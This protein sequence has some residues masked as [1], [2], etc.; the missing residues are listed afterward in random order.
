MNALPIT[1]AFTASVALLCSGC[2]LSDFLAPKSA[3]KS[4]AATVKKVKTTAYTHAE[5]S[6]RAWGRSNAIGGRLQHGKV[7]SASADWSRYPVGTRFKIQQ[8]G[9]EYVIDDYGSA[10]VGTNTIDLYTASMGEMRRW[11]VRQVDIEILEWGSFE[12]SLDI[13]EDR[14]R[15]RHVRTMVASLRQKQSALASGGKT[16]GARNSNIQL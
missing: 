11:G 15:N 3:G 4:V 9:Q 1:Y 16:G 5:R 10:L 6:H 8:T 2:T 14:Q 12:K 13:L 7:V